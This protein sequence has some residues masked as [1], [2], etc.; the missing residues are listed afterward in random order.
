MGGS[1]TAE[2]GVGSLEVDSLSG[3]ND[4]TLALDAPVSVRDL[5]AF[6]GTLHASS[7][8][9]SITGVVRP[10]EDHVPADGLIAHFDM[11]ATNLLETY[12][13]N[14]TNFVTKWYDRSGQ[15]Y[16]VA[17]PTNRP[18]IAKGDCNGLDVLCTGPFCQLNQPTMANLPQAGWLIWDNPDCKAKTVIEVIGLQEGGNFLVCC[19]PNLPCMHRGGN[20]GRL[21]TDSILAG[22]RSEPGDSLYSADA[23]FSINGNRVTY[24]QGF[25]SASYHTFAAR[26][27]DTKDPGYFYIGQ[28]GKDRTYRWGGQRVCEVLAYSRCLTDDE[29]GRLEAYLQA[30]WFGRAYRDYVAA[31]MGSV[32]VAASAVLDLGGERRTADS[33]SGSGVISNG[34]L[35]VTGMLAPSNLTVKGGVAFADGATLAADL[36]TGGT[37]LSVEGSVSFSTSGTVSLTLATRPTGEWTLLTATSFSGDPAGW[38]LNV[39]PALPVGF[40]SRIFLQ[41]GALKV[42]FLNPCTMLIFR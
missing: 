42:R 30:K 18:W 38:T 12:E 7:G 9:V 24:S 25:P 23:F 6:E 31:G 35:L 4:V 41:D 34:T 16:A 10:D 15:R 2:E 22:S 11:A 13:E 19:R 37:P 5:S 8:F 29:L 39:T 17:D 1:L 20:T 27:D 32:D 3:T 36:R 26:V 40:R 21:Y 14:G 33:V 28:F